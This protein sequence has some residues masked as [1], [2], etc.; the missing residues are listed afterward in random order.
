VPFGPHGAI[1]LNMDEEF[2]HNRITIIGSQASA[3]WRNPDRD[4]PRWTPARAFAAT[5]DCFRRGLLTGAPIVTPI[6]PF[7]D[8]VP[9]LEAAFTDPSRAIKLGV[10]MN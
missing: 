8:A 6:V 4:H 3:Y 10:K 7:A 9:A 5:I 1:H 2:H